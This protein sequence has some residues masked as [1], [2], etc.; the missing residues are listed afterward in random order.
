MTDETFKRKQPKLSE[1]DVVRDILGGPK[2]GATPLR[3]ATYDDFR[4]VLSHAAGIARTQTKD[5]AAGWN[6]L[7]LKE[8]EEARDAE[9]D[10][11][12]I[13]E[14]NEVINEMQGKLPED[15]P[16]YIKDEA[17]Q[18]QNEANQALNLWYKQWARETCGEELDLM[19]KHDLSAHELGKTLEALDAL[20]AN[21]EL[22]TLDDEHKNALDAHLPTVL[23]FC[24]DFALLQARKDRREEEKGP[25]IIVTSKEDL[26]KAA[27]KYCEH[28][29]ITDPEKRAEVWK[30]LEYDLNT[31]EHVK[32]QRREPFSHKTGSAGD[33]RQ[34]GER[35]I[36]LYKAANRRPPADLVKHFGDQSPPKPAM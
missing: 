10:P 1:S 24:E 5:F 21:C 20:Q 26:P 32:E 4:R 12:K 19:A 6:R 13:D 3:A 30:M 9:W 23:V 34:V 14:L 15:T 18:E 33:I 2:M 31:P 35:F 29:G 27:E 8:I 17:E 7:I 28:Y 16:E 22:S 25:Q 36:N 11:T